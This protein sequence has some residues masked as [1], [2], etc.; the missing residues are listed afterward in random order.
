[1]Y[2]Q[3][4]EHINAVLCMSNSSD[5][6]NRTLP[7]SVCYLRG[8]YCTCPHACRCSRTISRC[9]RRNL[10]LHS[11]ADERRRERAN[12]HAAG[13]GEECC[14]WCI[15]FDCDVYMFRL[16][17]QLLLVMLPLLR[18]PSSTTS[19]TCVCCC[20]VIACCVYDYFSAFVSYYRLSSYFSVSTTSPTTCATG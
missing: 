2:Y 5:T 15:Q 9:L 17:R 3:C 12:C 18:S 16:F 14:Y 7:V 1:M 11:V 4:R 10:V 8:V 13:G 19:R 6:F 20:F